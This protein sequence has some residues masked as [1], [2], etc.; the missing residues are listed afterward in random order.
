MLNSEA[1]TA[2]NSIMGK[3][4]PTCKMKIDEYIKSS[5]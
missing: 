3:Y 4:D 5:L 1:I 2:Q